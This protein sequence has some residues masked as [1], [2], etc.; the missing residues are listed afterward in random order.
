R[1]RLSRCGRWGRG[2]ALHP[3][4]GGERPGWHVDRDERFERLTPNLKPAL[5]PRPVTLCTGQWPDLPLETLAK[6]ASDWGYDGLELACWGDHFDVERALAE[7]DYCS[8]RRELL[9]RH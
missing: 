1:S 5:M 7:D 6:K 2:C 8:K 9:E 3:R 4:R